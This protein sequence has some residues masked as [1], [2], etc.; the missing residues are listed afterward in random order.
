AFCDME[1][2]FLTQAK[3]FG[4]YPLPWWGI[5]TSATYQ[6]YRSPQADP[7][8]T[9]AGVAGSWSVPTALIAPSLGRPLA[10]GARTASVNIIPYGGLYA[11]RLHQI[12][13]RIS[14]N[15]RVGR[16]RVQPQVDLY[17]LFNANTVLA[18]NTA[19]AP[20]PST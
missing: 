1:G 2:P 12:D 19:Y 9:L 11:D 6:T 20:P 4:I 5:Q 8:S 13:L 17:N 15:I 18:K 16:S 7:L 3:V 10:G 14:K